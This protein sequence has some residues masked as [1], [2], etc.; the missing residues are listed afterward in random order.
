ME[1]VMESI[2]TVCKEIIGNY[3]FD[4]YTTTTVA[5]N[6]VNTSSVGLV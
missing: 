6:M 1:I 4:H 5:I 3:I 2:F